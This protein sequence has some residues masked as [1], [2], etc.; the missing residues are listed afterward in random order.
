MS[1]PTA[2]TPD[3]G[4]AVTAPRGDTPRRGRTRDDRGQ[5]A[6]EFTGMVPLIL[7]VLILLW[8]G[9]LVGYTFSLAGNAADEAVRAATVAENSRIDEC[10]DA[11][12]EDLPDSWDIAGIDCWAEEENDLVRAEVELDVPILF[13]G[14]DI[15]VNVTGKA[16]APRES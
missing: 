3:E 2:E 10:T 15:D 6:V 9:A 4:A 8:Q 5:A 12:E 11:A 16:A 1:N 7:A 13:P 14:F